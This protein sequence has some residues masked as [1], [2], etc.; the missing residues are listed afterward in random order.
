L[1][2]STAY[3]VYGVGSAGFRLSDNS[4]AENCEA[5]GSADAF[6]VSGFSLEDGTLTQTM[7][8]KRRVVLE[9]YQKEI[10][11]KYKK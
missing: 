8:V 2:N 9:R 3:L 10:D 6:A 4:S 1:K 5:I 11:A 7:K